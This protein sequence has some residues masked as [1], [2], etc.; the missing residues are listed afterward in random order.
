MSEHPYGNVSTEWVEPV[1]ALRTFVIRD[2]QLDSVVQSGG[3]WVEGECRAV[4]LRAPQDE[5]PPHEAPG[6]DCRCG[7]YGALSLAALRRQYGEQARWIVTVIQCEGTGMQGPVGI[8]AARALV[9]A[10]WC[11]EPDDEHRNHIRL[12]LE[13]FPYARQY[14]NDQA[15]A[16]AYRIGEPRATR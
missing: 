16:L 5:A 3:H 12:C 11:P 6:E 10:F 7:I 4:C 2:G 8:R 1:Y 14:R 15:M 13:Q 9:V